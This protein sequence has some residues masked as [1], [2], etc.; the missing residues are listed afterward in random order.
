[1][2]TDIVIIALKIIGGLLIVS[3]I[4]FWALVIIIMKAS[5][6]TDEVPET[7]KG[8]LFQRKK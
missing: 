4:L 1:M 3:G 8:L 6:D 2:I 7:S 5:W